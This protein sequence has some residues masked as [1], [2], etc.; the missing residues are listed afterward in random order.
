MEQL[1]LFDLLQ[2]PNKAT[3]GL[4]SPSPYHVLT[5]TCTTI[6]HV[7][8]WRYEFPFIPSGSSQ[9]YHRIWIFVMI[10]YRD[11]ESNAWKRAVQPFCEHRVWLA[12]HWVTFVDSRQCGAIEIEKC[13]EIYFIYRAHR[14][15]P[16]WKNKM[17]NVNLSNN[18]NDFVRRAAYC[19]GGGSDG[20]SFKPNSQTIEW[21]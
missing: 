14:S 6:N 9:L 17:Y 19:G 2:S 21:S 12:L 16:I 13:V 18:S 3:S 20:I 1:I 5:I 10:F 8:R 4:F 7:T 11:T 15:H